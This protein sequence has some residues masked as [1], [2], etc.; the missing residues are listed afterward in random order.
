MSKRKRGEIEVNK[1]I[2]LD[3]IGIGA[4]ATKSETNLMTYNLA[5]NVKD[6]IKDQRF[7]TFLI[8]NIP[9]WL[10]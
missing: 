5:V 3:I 10:P 4:V 6:E 2:H 9:A 8:L 7:A 1:K